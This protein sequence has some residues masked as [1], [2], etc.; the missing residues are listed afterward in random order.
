MSNVSFHTAAVKSPLE[1]ARQMLQQ[2]PTRT[3]LTS[4]NPKL[5]KGETHG[6]HTVGLH[7]APST[8]SGFQVCP[9]STAGCAAGCLNT[10]GRGGLG[11][12][13]ENPNTV[14]RARRRRTRRYFSD[15]E[16]F[17][18]ALMIGMARE[19]K[20]AQKADLTP[21]FRLNL[22]SDIQWERQPVSVD[23]EMAEY[24]SRQYQIDIEPGL[25][26]SIMTVFADYMFYDYTKHDPD[27]RQECHNYRLTFSRAETYRNHRDM[28]KALAAGWNVAVVFSTRKGEPLPSEYMGHT[29]IDGDETDLRF[30]DPQGVVVG[31]RA[32]GKAKHDTSGFVVRVA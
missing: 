31:L 12:T 16:A 3:F 32:K 9:M 20:R 5:E 21:V 19:I 18:T 27:V 2:E 13:A 6:F 30:L 29:V 23:T 8:D 17:M 24:L 1:R 4:K 15:R 26:T 11:N 25:Y 7:L 28:K 22:T 10:A 14:Q